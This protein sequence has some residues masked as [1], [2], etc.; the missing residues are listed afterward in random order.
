[1]SFP[2]EVWTPACRRCFWLSSRF[3]PPN[4]SDVYSQLKSLHPT[5][6]PSLLYLNT[7]DVSL[8][9]KMNTRLTPVTHAST[10]AALLHSFIFKSKELKSDSALQLHLRPLPVR[11]QIFFFFFFHLVYMWSQTSL[12]KVCTRGGGLEDDLHIHMRE[13]Q[14]CYWSA[15]PGLVSLSAC[16]LRSRALPSVSLRFLTIEAFLALF[17]RST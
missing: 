6:V 15:A 2:S 7:A 13:R 5:H 17:F 9:R 3:Q 16:R 8:T 14:G 12:L 4:L 11:V 1:M 10:P